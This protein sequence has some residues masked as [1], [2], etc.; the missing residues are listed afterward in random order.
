MSEDVFVTHFKQCKS[1]KEH[2]TT[3]SVFF[4]NNLFEHQTSKEWK[5]LL[6]AFVSLRLISLSGYKTVKG[7]QKKQKKCILTKKILTSWCISWYVP[8]CLDMT[9]RTGIDFQVRKEVLLIWKLFCKS[10]IWKLKLHHGCFDWLI[11]FFRWRFL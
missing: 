6:L 11:Y 3:T 9:V 4:F 10:V 8:H 2:P 1:S 5:W 7:W